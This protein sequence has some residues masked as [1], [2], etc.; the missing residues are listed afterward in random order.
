MDNQE[1]FELLASAPDT[2]VVNEQQIA[3]RCFLCGDSTKNQYKK[4]LYIY[5]D[6]TNPR[7]YPTYHCFNCFE[8]GIFTSDMLHQMGIDSKDAG[9]YLRTLY[10]ASKN[11]DGSRVYKNHNRKDIDVKLP[12]LVGDEKTL[13]KI[14]YLYNRIGY[15]IPREDFNR[16]KIVFNLKEFLDYNNIKPNNQLVDILDRDYIGF[17]SVRNEYIILRDITNLNK[18]RY[19]KYNIFNIRNDAQSF[20]VSRASIDPLT[21][22]DIHI[23]VTEGTFDT[24]G[25]MYNVLDG[26]IDNKIF[27]ST[28]DGTFMQPILSFMR[29][30]LVGNNIY[31]DAYIDNDT[32]MDLKKIKNELKLFTP[33]FTVYYNRLSK[34]FGVPRDQI[35]RDILII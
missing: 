16:L 26:D 28:C 14:K 34:D 29:K 24:L 8:S 18:F 10:K 35:D 7:D 15:R 5:L 31:I 23:I 9:T 6:P 3:T 4:R 11:D 22:E 12:P 27:I 20:Y 21:N 2:R 30:G 33:N 25:V 1:L 13:S 32:R 19:V 17:L